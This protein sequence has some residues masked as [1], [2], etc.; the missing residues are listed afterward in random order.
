MPYRAQDDGVEGVVITFVDIT[1]RRRAADA[2][3]SAKREAQQANTAKSRFLAAASHDLRQPLQALSLMRGV[4]ARKIRDDKKE[5]ALA[6]VTRLD[7]TSAAMTGMLNTLLDINQLEAGTVHPQF[8]GFPIED[9]L[10]RLRDEFNYHAGAQSLA[11][12]VVRCGLSSTAT[13]ACSSR[14]S[15]TCY[16]TR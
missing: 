6:L 16:Q 2:L 7:E 9:L 5:E 15:A 1:E 3:E 10:D 12:R 14:C 13:R 4:L 8:V 11:L